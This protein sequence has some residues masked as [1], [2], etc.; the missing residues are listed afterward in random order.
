VTT[1]NDGSTSRT[2]SALAQDL[3]GNPVENGTVIFFGLVDNPDLAGP[4]YLGYISAG[5]NGSTNGTMTF[6]SAGNS[7][8]TDGLID[9]DILIILEGQ[10]EGGHRIKSVDSNTAL[11][12]YNTMNGSESGLDF[13]AGYAELGTVCGSVQTG[14]LE[15]DSYCT[16]T[17]V[18]GPGSIKGVAHTK[19]TWV[20][21]GIFKPYFLY[22]ESVG[23]DVGDTLAD[24]YAGVE[25]GNY[26]VTIS[27]NSV[28][29]GT[30][31]ISVVA[32][33]EDGADN[34]I[35]GQPVVFSSSNPG[36][37]FISGPNPVITNSNGIVATTISTTSCLTTN[38]TVTISAALGSLG[39]TATLSVTGTS[40]T[41]QF[42]SSGAQ[43]TATYADNSTT[44]A[45]TT[46]TAWSWV[47]NGGTPATNNTSTP[48]TVVYNPATLPGTFQTTLTVSNSLGCVSSP[49]SQ[50][51]L[52]ADPTADPPL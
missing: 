21:Q 29:S 52:V 26:T 36:V 16:P 4:P 9:D 30:T 10:D 35:Q 46:L 37:A 47:F 33:F 11:T 43:G 32:E 12:L 20:P 13:V 34:P 1:N 31:G 50:S 22:A 5:A 8:T 17:T 44:P 19:L 23:G 40:P 24:G 14:N 15:M 18:G 45:G 3:H 28:L 42:T 51:V 48:P 25:N 41:A 6:S 27:P 2:L 38:E 49:V 7:F 39:A